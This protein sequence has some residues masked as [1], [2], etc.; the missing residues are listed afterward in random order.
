MILKF[1]NKFYSKLFSLRVQDQEME[2][3][4]QQ[5]NS[6][7]VIYYEIKVEVLFLIC[8][9]VRCEL[10]EGIIFPFYLYNII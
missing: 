6:Y 10:V 8:S 1:A 5:H 7:V 2:D 9:H 3:V 4:C